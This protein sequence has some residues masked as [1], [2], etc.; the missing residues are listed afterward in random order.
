MLDRFHIN[1]THISCE[2][3]LDIIYFGLM[4]HFQEI[5]EAVAGLKVAQN[6][7]KQNI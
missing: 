3:Y 2:F 7:Y 5:Q 1:R 6:M 4:T